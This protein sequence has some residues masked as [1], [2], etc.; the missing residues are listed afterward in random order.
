MPMSVGGVK[1]REGVLK[2]RNMI[3]FEQVHQWSHGDPPGDRQT[4]T[5]ENF[6]FLHLC[7]WKSWKVK[8]SD[9][10]KNRCIFQLFNYLLQYL[11][12]FTRSVTKMKTEMPVAS[13]AYISTCQFHLN[14]QNQF[15]SSEL[16]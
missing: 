5:T 15:V 2:E 8:L 9:S 3:D 14:L 4:N 16:F 12:Q 1:T 11:I 13:F 6:T 10:C 7:W